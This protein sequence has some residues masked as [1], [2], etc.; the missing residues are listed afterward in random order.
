MINKFDYGD[1]VRVIR[2]IRNDGTYPDMET[3]ALLIRRGSIGNVQNLGT[4]LEDQIIYTV[5]FFDL[6][7]IV[8]CREE[9]LIAG[10][11]PM[12]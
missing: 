8:G 1:K 11:A 12:L 3:G 9:E 6:N 7:R 5:H 4:F 10:D 2:N